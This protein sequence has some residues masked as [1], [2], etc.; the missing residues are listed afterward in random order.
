M[1]AWRR[2]RSEIFPR[3]KLSVVASMSII[4][5]IRSRCRSFNVFFTVILRRNTLF[6]MVMMRFCSGGG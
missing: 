4:R 2:F 1:G 5:N 6:C 3:A